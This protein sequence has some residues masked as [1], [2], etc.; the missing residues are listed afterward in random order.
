[1]HGF[2]S[3]DQG[4]E[5]VVLSRGYGSEGGG[6]WRSGVLVSF[7]KFSCPALELA[8]AC[9]NK[10]LLAMSMSHDDVAFDFDVATS[11]R[12][13]ALSGDNHRWGLENHPLTSNAFVGE[14]PLSE[15]RARKRARL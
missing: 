7:I 12:Q 2:G 13:S 14:S 9:I 5:S 3:N 8:V 15:E 11:A 6:W 10:F 1:M 4:K